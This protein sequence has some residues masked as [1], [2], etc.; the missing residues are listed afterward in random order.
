LGLGLG[1]GGF[2]GVVGGVTWVVVFRCDVFFV[3]WDGAGVRVALG[4]KEVLGEDA[5]LRGCEVDRDF[6][7]A[8]LVTPEHPLM[9]AERPTTTRITLAAVSRFFIFLCPRRFRD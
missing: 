1:F 7:L 6:A 8:R 3:E 4:V 2:L 9:V 5:E